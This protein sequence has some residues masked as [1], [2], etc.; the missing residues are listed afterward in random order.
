MW[1]S[2]ESDRTPVRTG[3]KFQVQRYACRITKEKG[4]YEVT[5]TPAPSPKNPIMVKLIAAIDQSVGG[6][7]ADKVEAAALMNHLA[8]NP[9]VAAAF[10]SVLGLILR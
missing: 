4:P 9:L 10:K 2:K 5:V 8:S 6:S 1:A 3:A 7:E